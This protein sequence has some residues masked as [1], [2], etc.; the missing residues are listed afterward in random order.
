M[1]A[2]DRCETE[3][4]T[5]ATWGKG[6]QRPYFTSWVVLV[7]KRECICS[8]LMVA[9]VNDAKDLVAGGP[10]K[11]WVNGEFDSSEPNMY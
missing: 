10:V 11:R 5:Q 1:G 3:V 2:A 4:Q 9:S 7:I 6:N 8:S